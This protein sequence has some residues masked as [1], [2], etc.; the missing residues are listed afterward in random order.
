MIN[1]AEKAILFSLFAPIALVCFAAY[2][3]GPADTRFRYAAAIASAQDVAQRP[4]PKFASVFAEKIP[5]LRDGQVLVQK[6][7]YLAAIDVEAKQ[8]AWIVYRV[9]RADWDTDNVLERNFSTPEELRDIC[10]EQSDYESSGFDLGHLYGLQFVSANRY[11]S[12]VNQ[13]CAIAAQRPALNR[14]PWLRVENMIKEASREK[15]VDVIAGLLWLKDM[16]K[17]PAA[18]EAHK[19]ASHCWIIFGD[20]TTEQAYLFP[21]NVDISERVDSYKIDPIELRRKVSPEWWSEK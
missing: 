9:N 11:A 15:P 14:G 19:I 17:L 6:H 2:D 18:E 8:P 7:L 3:I 4:K 12:E 5:A 21:Q 1:K 16:P 20:G 13:L 10:L